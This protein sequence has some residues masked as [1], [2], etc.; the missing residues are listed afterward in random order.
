MLASNKPRND[1]ILTSQSILVCVCETYA[2]LCMGACVCL[3]VCVWCVLVCAWGLCVCDVC[4]FYI[5]CVCT[6]VLIYTHTHMKGQRRTPGVLLRHSP[7]YFH[8]GRV[9]HW[10]RSS[11]SLISVRLTNQQAP[12]ILHSSDSLNFRTEVTWAL[13]HPWFLTWVLGM[14]MQVLM[15]AW[16][17][18]LSPEPS[19]H[20]SN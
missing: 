10:T 9:S 16:Q 12:L 15:P 3:C 11:L 5:V 7:S 13:C 18:L 6:C 2:C 17:V 4:L 19:Y 20:P 8:W 14:E 1:F